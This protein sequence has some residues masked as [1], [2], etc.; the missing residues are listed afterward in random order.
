MRFF[1]FYLGLVLFIVGLAYPL[2]IGEANIFKYI[3][4]IGIITFGIGI[5]L[6]P[7]KTN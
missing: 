7:G 5:L 1:V 4:Y 3:L 2:G 6:L